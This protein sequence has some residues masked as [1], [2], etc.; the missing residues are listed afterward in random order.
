[1]KKKIIASRDWRDYVFQ[2]FFSKKK[3]VIDVI[4]SFRF[5]QKNSMRNWRNHV[6]QMKKKIIARRDWRDRVFQNFF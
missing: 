4:T 3:T 1:M 2:N 6:F 5:F